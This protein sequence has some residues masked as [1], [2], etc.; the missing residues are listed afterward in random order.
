MLGQWMLNVSLYGNCFVTDITIILSLIVLHPIVFI[1]VL[2]IDIS[3]NISADIGI[4]VTNTPF[5]TRPALIFHRVECR[6]SW[7]RL[8]LWESGKS[9]GWIEHN[10]IPFSYI[11][12]FLYVV[13][14]TKWENSY[15]FWIKMDYFTL[16]Y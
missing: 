7:T 1:R 6:L 14:T 2:C 9:F 3:S 12:Q 13:F 15:F 4:S 16:H 8:G 10:I 11:F 5:L